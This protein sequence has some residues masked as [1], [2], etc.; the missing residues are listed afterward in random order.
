M[1][2]ALLLGVIALLAV[3]ILGAQAETSET[4]MV[5]AVEV[6]DSA[7]MAAYLHNLHESPRKLTKYD[8]WVARE[9]GIRMPAAAFLEVY[10]TTDIEAI[11]QQDAQHE[12]AFRAEVEQEEGHH[13]VE[14]IDHAM[15]LEHEA[16]TNQQFDQA[17]AAGHDLEVDV[18]NEQE[19]LAAE[20]AEAQQEEGSA[21]LV[22]VD[23]EADAEVE[24]EAETE[25]ETGAESEAEREVHIHV[26]TKAHGSDASENLLRVEQEFDA[27]HEEV[28]KKLNRLMGKI[29]RHPDT[30][31]DKEGEHTFTLQQESTRDR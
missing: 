14:E 30:V 10:G 4:E 1:R 6:E 17:L 26:Q 7:G 16:I 25:A 28:M 18:G 21:A 19:Q 5:Q 27:K 20:Q 23:A 13:F 8:M 24:A 31:P 12:S 15:M 11:E 3:A 9:R 2:A 29:T 22:E